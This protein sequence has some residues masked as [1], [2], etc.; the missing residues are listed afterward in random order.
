MNEIIQKLLDWCD[1]HDYDVSIDITLKDKLFPYV[2]VILSRDGYRVRHIFNLSGFSENA[3][4]FPSDEWF[5]RHCDLELQSFLNFA[6]DEF[7]VHE[8]EAKNDGKV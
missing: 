2:S 1:E 7:K 6:E 4:I 8:A 5:D 3:N